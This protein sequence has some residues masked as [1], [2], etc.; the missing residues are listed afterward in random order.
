MLPPY[1]ILVAQEDDHPEAQGIT[2]ELRDI[3]YETIYC[4]R[5]RFD[6]MAQDALQEDAD[7][8][9]YMTDEIQNRTEEAESYLDGRLVLTT[10]DDK[11]PIELIQSILEDDWQR[12][13]GVGEKT[14]TRLATHG[15]APRNTD[16]TA[17]GSVLS[18][19]YDETTIAP[20]Y[21]AIRGVFE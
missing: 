11:E 9:V 1:R 21:D 15:M 19:L 20:I 16:I 6:H 17:V 2:R 3:G 4:E 12:I 7:A 10:D 5:D 18:D 14:S 8:V 13:D